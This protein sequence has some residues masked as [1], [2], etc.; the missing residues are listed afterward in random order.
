MKKIKNKHL[1]SV[2]IAFM[3]IAV[4][5]VLL[6]IVHKSNI[7][8]SEKDYIDF[9][10]EWYTEDGETAEFLGIS[11]K[12]TVQKTLP[13]VE[14]DCILY[15]NIKSCNIKVYK[16]DECVYRSVQ[17]EERFFGKTAGS[18]FVEVPIFREDSGKTL[19]MDIHNPY[20]D[21]SGKVTKIYL[22]DGTDILRTTVNSRLM[23]FLISVIITF[24]GLLFIVLFIPMRRRKVVGKEMLYF[25]LFA[26]HMGVFM[27]T[28]CKFLQVLF[29]N[30][31]IYHMIAELY[32]MLIVVPML[33]FLGQMYQECTHRIVVTV[34]LF[35]IANFAICYILHIL[36]IKDYH[37]TIWITHSTYVIGIVAVAFVII[38]NFIKHRKKNLY[39][40]IGVMLLGVG[41]ICDIIAWKVGRSLE[42]TFFTRMGVLLFMCLEGV[43]IIW[44]FME[45]YQK[46]IKMQLL[47]KLA[48]QDGLTELLNRT[49]FMEDVEKQK[50]ENTANTLVA[51][52][53]VNHLKYVND[54]YGHAMGDEMIVTV[55]REMTKCLGSLGKCYRIGGDEFVFI[56]NA[57]NI[58]AR[59]LEAN[60]DLMDHLKRV[61]ETEEL[62]FSISIA[63]GYC[64]MNQDV[65]HTL[66]DAI[67]QADANMYI[68]K[69]EIKSRKDYQI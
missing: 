28:D 66:S 16:D 48:Y 44:K 34:C 39:H 30:A 46:G 45:Q 29:P 33:L 67:N 35:G 51:M 5:T 61:K 17:H 60:R 32:M 2:Y 37:E 6:S 64:M 10:K 9:S 21:G 18:Y 52:F 1:I 15:L 26:F 31:H 68:N 41:A 13:H 36:G 63:M 7:E 12:Y 50:Y 3:M 62:P 43:Q 8:W 25:G 59:F 4:V 23:G 49:S 47:R 54:T 58:E 24:M 42:T 19:T 22:G 55:A 56:S 14:E 69:K 53:D 65:Y 20:E 11:G 27:L 40:N 38:K 57:D